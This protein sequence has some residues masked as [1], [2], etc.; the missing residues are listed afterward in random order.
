[1]YAAQDSY[2][3][4]LARSFKERAQKLGATIIVEKAYQSNETQFSTLLSELKAAKPDLV[5]VPVYYKDMVQIAR[6]AKQIDMQ[7]SLFMG[8][9]GWDSADLIEGAGDILEGAYLTNL[10]AP[11]VPWPNS[12]QFLAAFRAK[13]K[14]DP[15]SNSAQG[16]DAAKLLFD[17][18]ARATEVT[19][20]A[21][22]T[23]LAQTKD[24]VGATGTLTIDKD[25]NANKPIVIAQVKGKK[26]T[27]SSQMS[28]Q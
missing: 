8:S 26:F 1:M 23:A 17:A 4:G 10:Y 12:Q 18:I 27:Y 24:F 11:D 22:K 20:E 28:S 13:Y 6:Q 14:H 7:G 25:H 16:Y 19:P 9:D 5:F 2:S 3:S 21:I 15:S